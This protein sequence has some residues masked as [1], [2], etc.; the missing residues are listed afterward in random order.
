M[1]VFS[2]DSGVMS[3]GINDTSSWFQSIAEIIPRVTLRANCFQITRAH[4]ESVFAFLAV[5]G[6]SPA[7][8]R[9]SRNY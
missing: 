9:N 5:L 3:I 8:E 7:L 1:S 2:R 4:A 6:E